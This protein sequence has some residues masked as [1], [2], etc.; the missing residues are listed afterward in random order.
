[1]RIS[2]LTP[3]DIT[4]ARDALNAAADS[5]DGHFQPGFVA[6]PRPDGVDPLAWDRLTEHVARAERVSEVVR[7]LGLD[8]ALS[9]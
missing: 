3:H 6:P 8:A 1:M 9:R 4:R 7:D 5:W 2:W